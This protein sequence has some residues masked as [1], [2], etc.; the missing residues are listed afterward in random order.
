V[1]KPPVGSR[2]IQLTAGEN[3]APR[4]SSL[5]ELRLLG[6]P[7]L[8]AAIAGLEV[9]LASQAD[10]QGAVHDQSET[11]ASLQKDAAALHAAVED[12]LD[13]LAPDI[14]LPENQGRPTEVLGQ[15]L[16]EAAR[17]VG[18]TA[19]SLASV[20]ELRANIAD[21]LAS[22]NVPRPPSRAKY[23]S[24]GVEDAPAPLPAAPFDWNS[25][26]DTALS[27]PHEG[28]D[29]VCHIFNREWIGIRAAAGAL[30]GNKLA[31]SATQHMSAFEIAQVSDL[32]QRH[33]IT[34]LAFQG[35]S[36]PLHALILALARTGQFDM[37]LVWHGAPA[38]WMMEHERKLVRAALELVNKGILKKINIMR[39]GAEPLIGERAYTKLLLNMPPNV[40]IA[41]ALELAGKKRADGQRIAFI[42]SWHL[43]HKNVA[44]CTLAAHVTQKITDIW[45][46]DEKVARQLD[47]NEK[48]K[49]L[50]PRHGRAMLE[51]MREAD[52]VI[53]ASLIDC[54]PMVDLEALAVGTPCVRGPLFL[55]G[56][57]SHEYV[58]LTETKNVL[59]IADLSATMTNVLSVPDIE[60]SEMMKDYRQQLIELSAE[61]YR[62]FLE[63]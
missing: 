5:D 32:L 29:Q 55:D 16:R 9:E 21:A 40:R 53:N 23:V 58:K 31:I 35:M 54:H 59:S 39:R 13:T 61:R 7:R 57:E 48:V 8:H 46:L 20:Q 17:N 4:A 25:D 15:A 62:D 18:E 37:H 36:E 12:A 30:P 42:P 44:S 56:L 1:L 43:L 22:A 51:T 33:G 34:K 52:L 11:I 60:I 2:C 63:L 27:N 49:I 24:A 41:A 38:M 26:K 10:L 19:R 50:G 47:Y 14:A 45:L 28:F 3:S 6:L